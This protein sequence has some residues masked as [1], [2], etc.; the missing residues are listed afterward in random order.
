MDAS[1]IAGSAAM[2]S[3]AGGQQ[4]VSL[5]ALKRAADAQNQIA[6]M[7]ATQAQQ[8]QQP[9]PDPQYNLSVYA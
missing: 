8:P 3:Q 5:S 7:L 2:L 1:S 6:N 4:N 9:Q